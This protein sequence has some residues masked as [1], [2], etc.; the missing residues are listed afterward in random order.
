MDVNI[1]EGSLSLEQL[2]TKF[3]EAY[4]EIKKNVIKLKKTNSKEKKVYYLTSDKFAQDYIN[5]LN[6]GKVNLFKEQYRKYDLLIIDDIQFFASKQKIQEEFFHLF[7]FH[8]SF[9]L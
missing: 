1:I 8:F 4:K 7:N 6:N 2:L 5:S 9:Y 3:R